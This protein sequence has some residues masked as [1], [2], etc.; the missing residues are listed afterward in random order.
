[1]DVME[2]TSET[3]FVVF[4]ILAC[5]SLFLVIWFGMLYLVS[6][7]AG[8][9]KLHKVYQFPDR[10]REPILVMSYQSIQ[11][12]MSNYNNVLKLT[13]Y[14]EGL[15]IEVMILFR[16]QHPKIFIPWKDINL[17]EKSESTFTWNNLEIGNPAITNI[18]VSDKVFEQMNN[19][20]K[21]NDTLDDS[22][23]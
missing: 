10:L 5:F 14:Q 7:F 13:Y 8:W 12:G 21:K 17:K 19:Y 11:I 20:I 1:M 15:G 6:R 23:W 4:I 3:I 22:R 18:Y 16:F 2:S 9:G